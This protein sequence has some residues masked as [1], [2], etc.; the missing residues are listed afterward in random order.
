MKKIL[1]LNNE[2]DV[3][4][5]LKTSHF[6][7]KIIALNYKVAIHCSQNNIKFIYIKD[8]LKNNKSNLSKLLKDS[9]LISKK[10]DKKITKSSKILANN[11]YFSNY[12]K[13]SVGLLYIQ[14]YSNY[15]NFLV[16]KFKE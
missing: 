6:Y 3:S 2:N 14:I 10:I 4:E 15:L 12:Q 9:F 11:N 7:D 8:I 1:I 16:N 5:Y 13:F